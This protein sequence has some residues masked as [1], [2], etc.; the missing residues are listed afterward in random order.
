MEEGS[1]VRVTQRMS[2]CGEAREYEGEV[3]W[4]GKR[5]F[6]VLMNTGKRVVFWYDV[7][8]LAGLRQNVE[9]LS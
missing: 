8:H 9:V 4:M 1:R 7:R 6:D 2:R 5:S 3:M